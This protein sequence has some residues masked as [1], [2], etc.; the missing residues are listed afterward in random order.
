MIKFIKGLWQLKIIKKEIS[1]GNTKL[2]EHLILTRKRQ[3]YK[4]SLLEKLFLENQRNEKKLKERNDKFPVQVAEPLVQKF[5]T[6]HQLI[7]QINSNF[8]LISHDDH[9]IECTGI[10]KL[11]FTKLEN[12]LAN[13]LQ[14]IIASSDLSDSQIKQRMNEAH[15]DLMS[16]KKGLDPTYDKNFSPHVYLIKYFLDN[17][18]CSYLAYFFIYQSGQLPKNITMLDI[19]AGPATILF[20]LSLFLESLTEHQGLRDFNCSYYSLEKERNLQY[21]GLQ[22]WR[23]YIDNLK[24]TPNIFYQFNT[25][26]IF[27]YANYHHKLPTGFFNVIVIAHC[28]FYQGE[29]RNK[30]FDI[31]RSIFKQCLRTDGKVLLVI[32]GNKFYKMFDGYPEEN[33]SRERYLIESFLS[34]LGLRLVFYKYLTST[35]QRINNKESFKQLIQDNVLPERPQISKLQEKYF[36]Y[37]SMAKYVIDDF[38]IYAEKQI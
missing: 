26:S 13:F 25:V 11:V 28:L 12:E 31:Y 10:E 2:A 22:L 23:Q 14:K 33:L 7:T 34:S 18:Y 36:H 3:G 29:Y 9:K 20:G 17:V 30:S 6:H 35:G 27:D 4:L 38:I 16:L 15:K 8:R 24:L 21:R 1:K 32:Q 37:S 5:P 19:A